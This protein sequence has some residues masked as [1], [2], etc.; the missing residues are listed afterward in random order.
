MSTWAYRAYRAEHMKRG[1]KGLGLLLWLLA[2]ASLVFTSGQLAAGLPV[3]RSLTFSDDFSS[4]NLNNWQ[5]PHPEDWAIL[6]EGSLHY[7]HMKR[8]REPGVP[9]RP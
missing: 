3:W 7:L 1:L 5:L 4:G 6:T 2:A 8:N 9:R